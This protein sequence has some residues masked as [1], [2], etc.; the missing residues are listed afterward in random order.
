[1]RDLTTTGRWLAALLLLGVALAT[2][3]AMGCVD[4]TGPEG[5]D[6]WIASHTD[7]V[8]SGAIDYTLIGPFVSTPVWT[9]DPNVQILGARNDSLFQP[10]NTSLLY[11]IGCDSLYVMF[12]LGELGTRKMRLH[13]RELSLNKSV[14]ITCFDND[15]STW[16][17][18]LVWAE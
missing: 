1:M 4:E 13:S 18:R 10:E 3:L 12:P 17:K 15:D 7:H 2:T 5:Q 9:S 16:V 11:L 8:I 14:V 6:T